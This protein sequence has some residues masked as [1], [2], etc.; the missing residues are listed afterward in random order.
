[1]DDNKDIDDPKEV[2]ACPT[3]GKR[4][5]GHCWHKNKKD[6]QGKKF[7]PGSAGKRA[8]EKM[9]TMEEIKELT[10][11]SLPCLEN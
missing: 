3:C 10:Q 7:C 11:L 6:K 4:H 2:R 9:Y 5:L 8:Q 1:M